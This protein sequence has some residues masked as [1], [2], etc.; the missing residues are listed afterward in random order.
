MLVI[1]VVTDLVIIVIVIVIFIVIFIVIVIVIIVIV[2][3]ILIVIIIILC[4]RGPLAVACLKYESLNH[5]HLG[6]ADCSKRGEYCRA[7]NR[8]T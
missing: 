6:H 8:G 1:V 3:V 7:W 2:I 4:P 5:S